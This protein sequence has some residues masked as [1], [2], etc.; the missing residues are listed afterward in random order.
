METSMTYP[1][2]SEG[3]IWRVLDGETFLMSKD[4]S[5]IHLLNKTACFAWEMS[6]GCTKVEDIV[7]QVVDRF[8]VDY[9]TAE[10]DV[11]DF[12]Q[13]LEEKGLAQFM[14]HPAVDK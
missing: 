7:S 8:D 6:D 10:Q 2:R 14:K 9:A 12:F 1:V 5:Q 3:V 4:G 11:L 13:A